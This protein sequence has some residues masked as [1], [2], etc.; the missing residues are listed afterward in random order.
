[1]VEGGILAIWNFAPV[2]LKVPDNVYMRNENMAASLAMISQIETA[3]P[4]RRERRSDIVTVQ[5]IRFCLEIERQGSI[6]RAA[7]QLFLSQP[8][9]SRALRDLEQELGIP[10]LNG[11]PPV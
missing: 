11:P 5:Q 10:C 8:N 7:E 9:L 3:L 6:T 2:N 4:R 1:M